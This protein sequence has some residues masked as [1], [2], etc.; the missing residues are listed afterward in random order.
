MKSNGA[1][2]LVIFAM[3]ALILVNYWTGPQRILL[4]GTLGGT[5]DPRAGTTTVTGQTSSATPTTHA[6]VHQAGTG[7]TKKAI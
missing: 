3:M 7:G 6:P 4:A 5:A 2:T 1:V